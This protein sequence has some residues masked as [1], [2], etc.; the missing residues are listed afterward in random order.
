M[1]SRKLAALVVM[2]AAAIA[3]LAP[4]TASA[5]APAASAT[6]HPGVQT[7]TAGGQCTSNF[8]FQDGTNVY[9]GQ[10]AHCSSTGGQ[11]STDG[12]DTGSQPLGTPVEVSGASKP[13]TL[14][15]NSWLTMQQKGESDTD[16]C[17]YNDLALVKIDPTDVGKVNPS[18]PGF[19]GPTGLGP[20]SAMLGDTVY[21][22]GNS[23]L[24]LGVTKLSPKQGV[25]VQSE[26][27]GWSRDVVTATPGIPGD[28][29]SGFMS[30][31]GQAIGVLSTL[32]IAPLAGSNGVGD[33]RKEIDYMHANSSFSGANLVPG[34][35]PFKADLVG[36]ILGS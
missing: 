1:H 12:C 23:S 32:Q 6:I 31:S 24:R 11:T 29:G 10:A 3:A 28:S 2:V 35:E 7:V 17:A 16:T 14:V 26:G 15:Y 19:G 27:N 30:G 8:V 21:S 13:G 4:A 20:S 33:L 5:W 36:A 9:L 34:T 25:V 22:Y 18:V